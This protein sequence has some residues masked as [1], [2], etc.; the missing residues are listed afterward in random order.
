LKLHFRNEGT[1]R[2]LERLADSLGLSPD[3][4]AEVA[5]EHEL[6]AEGIGPS[7]SCREP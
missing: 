4:L 3:E 7:R 2:E 1:L 5:I 6:I